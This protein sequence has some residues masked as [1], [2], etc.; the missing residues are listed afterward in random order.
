MG[1][2]G[3]EGT[4]GCTGTAYSITALDLADAKIQLDLSAPEY[5]YGHCFLSKR[6]LGASLENLTEGKGF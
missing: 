1:Q 3:H 4:Q 6:L 2:L 5:E